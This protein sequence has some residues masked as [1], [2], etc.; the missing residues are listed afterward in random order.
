MKLASGAADIVQYREDGIT[1]GLGSDGT[2]SSNDLDMFA[3]MRLA[4]NLARLVRNDPAA[5]PASEIVRAATIDGAKALGMSE[6][7]GSLEVGKE[8]DIISINLREPHLIPIRDPFT[9]IV[10]SAG[11]SDVRHVF[12]AGEQVIDNRR[13]TKVDP[14]E[15]MSSALRHVGHLSQ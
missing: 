13:P 15:I 7:I 3:V 11:R 4:A 14:Q 2:S 1:V 8:A 12:V 9:T 6:R 10:Y 5:I